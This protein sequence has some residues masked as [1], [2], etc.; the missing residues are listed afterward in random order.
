MT[1]AI[2]SWPKIP[3]KPSEPTCLVC[4][5]TEGQACPG[6]CAWSYLDRVSGWGV[7]TVCADALCGLGER[8]IVEALERS[9]WKPKKSCPCPLCHKAK[10]RRKK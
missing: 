8:L 4:R 6:G 3:K 2:A 1:T 9:R 5:C 10:T 7:C